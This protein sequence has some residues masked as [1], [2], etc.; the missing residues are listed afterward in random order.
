MKRDYIQELHTAYGKLR[1]N[2]QPFTIVIVPTGF[3]K[4]FKEQLVESKLLLLKYVDE[5][6]KIKG[7][8]VFESPHI[9]KIQFY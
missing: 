2:E 4:G 3:C 9:N 7:C 5:D 6:L 8:K 1:F